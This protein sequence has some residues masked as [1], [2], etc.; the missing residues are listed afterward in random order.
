LVA[1]SEIQTEG[2]LAIQVVIAVSWLT[3]ESIAANDD[4][5]TQRISRTICSICLGTREDT[6]GF[7]ECNLSAGER[8]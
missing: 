6:R 1:W 5:G 4:V 3:D 7:V 8:K 2:E